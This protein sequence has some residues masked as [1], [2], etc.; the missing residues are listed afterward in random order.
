M[1]RR[2]YV[3]VAWIWSIIWYL[4]LDPIKWIMMYILNEDGVRDRSAFTAAKQARLSVQPRA[5]LPQCPACIPSPNTPRIA[6]A[7]NLLV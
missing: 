1:A 5:L 4:G 3:I 7:I 6:F 2:Y